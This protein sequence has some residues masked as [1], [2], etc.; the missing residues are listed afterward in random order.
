[1]N[2]VEVTCDRCGV[3]VVEAYEDE[4]FTSGFYRC[5]P[6]S[7]WEKFARPGEEVLCDPCMWQDEG[8]ANEY[9]KNDAEAQAFSFETLLRG[10]ARCGNDHPRIVFRRFR[11]YPINEFT[12]WALCPSTEE[13]VLMVFMSQ[14]DAE[15]E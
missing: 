2:N 11:R 3:T 6:G 10:C 4:F 15:H 12:H 14:K 9:G 8:Y 13:P 1:M 7:Y 5:G